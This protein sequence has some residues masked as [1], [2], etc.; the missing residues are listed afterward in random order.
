MGWCRALEYSLVSEMEETISM[1]ESDL[2]ERAPSLGELGLY[3]HRRMTSEEYISRHIHSSD[4][5][6][7]SDFFLMPLAVLTPHFRPKV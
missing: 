6:L 1:W 2:C 4:S 3:N 5:F 7:S